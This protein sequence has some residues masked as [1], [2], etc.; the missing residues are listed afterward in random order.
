MDTE[1]AENII[2]EKVE[3]KKMCKLFQLFRINV[4]VVGRAFAAFS[5]LA[6]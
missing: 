6:M 3:N 1:P 4:P 2:K 5:A